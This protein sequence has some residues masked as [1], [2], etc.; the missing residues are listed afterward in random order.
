MPRFS[1]W[2]AA[3]TAVL[4]ASS[5]LAACG[6]EEKG[7]S[8]LNSIA[9]VGKQ[10]IPRSEF[11]RAYGIYM[12]NAA[13]VD[14]ASRSQ[15]RRITRLFLAYQLIHTEWLE[16]EAERLGVRL[17]RDQVA[18]WYARKRASRR[19]TV[20]ARGDDSGYAVPLA[21]GGDAPNRRRSPARAELL[22][23]ELAPPLPSRGQ[24]TRPIRRVLGKFEDRLLKRYRPQTRCAPGFR[25]SL[26]ANASK[27]TPL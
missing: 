24:S 1:L 11:D 14:V 18:A 27:S 23:T 17:T 7:R 21:L 9:T 2:Q 10:A 20:A 6:T 16:Q 25:I 13:R 26:C 15:Q 19:R 8:S 3:A 22:A 5:C 12:R 4:L